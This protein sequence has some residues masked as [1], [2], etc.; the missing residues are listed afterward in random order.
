[1]MPRFHC[2]GW[3]HIVAAPGVDAMDITV[4]H[5]LDHI[6]Y[7]DIYLPDKWKQ[8]IR[9]NA[10]SQ[11]PGQ[12]RGRT[13]S[14][15]KLGF[16]SKAVYYYWLVVSR[17][18]WE[19][20]D[21]PIKS[22]QKFVVEKGEEHGV[23][24]LDI[25]AE[26]GTKILAFQVMD[27]VEEWARNTQELAMD[28]T[29]NTNGANFELFAAVADAKGSG[30]PLAFLLIH[31]TK[32][33]ASGAKQTL[34]ERFLRKLRALGVHPEFTLTDKDWS[35]INAMRAVWPNAKHQL[36]FWHAL[37]ALKQRLAKNKEHPAVYD[38]EAAHEKFSFIDLNFVPAGQQDPD[39]GIA[40]TGPGTA[41]TDYQFCPLPHRLPILRL[42]AKHA[43]QHPLLPER[44]GETR[45]SENIWHDAVAEM[46]H[47]CRANNLCEVWAYLWNS[48][49]SPS[50]W[51]LWARAAYPTSIPC[52]RTTMMVEALWRN[53]KRLVLHLYNRP[54]I[55][56]AVYAIITKAIP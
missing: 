1:R 19:L 28:S 21:D 22:A 47:H 44:H 6:A 17:E 31:T 4:K 42:F 24:L 52:K 3:L 16:S 11:T 20:D 33:A 2:S 46:Y 34:L 30:I 50:R 54:P 56:L 12:L 9:E 27:F 38:S 23:T 8:Y 35:E 43:S 14:D 41:R 53:L 49:Y 36:C 10:R 25:P 7:K 26:P 29:W 48:W 5:K 18:E 40:I 39:A 37:R 13:L 55:D 32:E 51:G 45:T 15:I